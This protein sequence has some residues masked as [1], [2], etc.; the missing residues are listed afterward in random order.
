MSQTITYEVLEEAELKIW[1]LDALKNYLRVSHEYDDQLIT[2]LLNCAVDL[3]AQHIGLALRKKTVL[4]K[5]KDLQTDLK[6]KYVP[7]SNIIKVSE[8]GDKKKTEIKKDLAIF[9]QTRS[10][11]SFDESL[12]RKDYEIIYEAGFGDDL[13]RTIQI[14][15][16]LMLEKMYERGGDTQITDLEVYRFFQCHRQVR[17]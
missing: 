3:A 7:V 10:M 5:V 13:P 2:N 12:H 1:T 8:I 16:L 14:G 9:E 11:I 4:M 17:I 15:I 6:L